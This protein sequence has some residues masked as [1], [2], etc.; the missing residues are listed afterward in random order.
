MLYQT[1]VRIRMDHIRFNMKQ[2]RQAVGN[3]CKILIAVKAN[4]YGHGAVEVA[5]LAEKTGMD[6]LGVATIP[7][8][9]QIREAGVRLPILKFSPAFEEEMDAALSQDLT[10]TVCEL[11]NIKALQRRCANLNINGCVH[12]KVETGMGRIGVS[13]EDAP[14][15]ALFIEKECPN[16][17]LE[18][19]FTHLPVSDHPERGFTES[20]IEQFKTVVDNIHAAI[21][22]R[23]KIIHCANSGAVLSHKTS[24]LDMVRPGVMIYGYYP[25]PKTPQSI[26]IKPG[27][28]IYTRVAFIKK[29]KAGTSIGYGRTWFSSRETW[30]ATLPVGYGD[31]F[32]RLFSNKGRVLISGKSYPVVGRV[33]M[34]QTMIDLGPETPVQVGDEVVLMGKSEDLE[35][36]CSEW[37]QVLHTI[38]YEV[39]CRID[40]RVSRV[41]EDQKGI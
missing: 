31:G 29:I 7:E 18:G 9:I 8:G 3:N 22:R 11:E 35:I 4:G 15:L 28:S 26:P 13:L 2:V 41:Y 10:L 6:W 30:I 27:M 12:L 17:N 20:Q 1:Y 36:T 38:P 39:T 24:W 16:L 19:V 5:Q 40:A 33:C 37:A 23:V 34:D 14:A 21:G 25:D 32:N